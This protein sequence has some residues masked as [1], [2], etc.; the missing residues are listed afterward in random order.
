VEL[1]ESKVELAN[2][3]PASPELPLRKRPTRR[4]PKPVM[5]CGMCRVILFLPAREAPLK[6][7]Q[8]SPV[9]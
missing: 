8:A 1:A 6:K 3:P 9:G 4:H 5:C 7:I 2:D